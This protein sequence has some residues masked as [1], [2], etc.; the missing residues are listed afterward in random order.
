METR[1]AQ[2]EN[3][4][5]SNIEHV[6][7]D[8]DKTLPAEHLFNLGKTIVRK[9][10]PGRMLSE[11][12]LEKWKPE[13]ID[14]IWNEM[15]RMDKEQGGGL[16]RPTGEPG[17]WKN[18]IET[19]L[20]NYKVSIASFSSFKPIIE[21]YL[22]E[23][24]G[25]KKSEI[26]KIRIEA[27]LPS[28]DNQSDKMRHIHRIVNN[29][30]P[31]TPI[32]TKKPL[33]KEEKIAV[34]KQSILI[35]DQRT[36]V[37]AIW[38]L[39]K[40]VVG[41]ENHGIKVESGGVNNPTVVIGRLENLLGI[42]FPDITPTISPAKSDLPKEAVR[43]FTGNETIDFIGRAT[44]EKLLEANSSYCILR[45][46]KE[47]GMLTITFF[48]TTNEGTPPSPAE[49]NNYRFA[50][51]RIK[52]PNSLEELK[53]IL[54]GSN[55]PK[56]KGLDLESLTRLNLDSFPKQ[57]N[58]EI[59]KEKPAQPKLSKQ[60]IK[61]EPI[62]IVLKQT[63]TTPLSAWKRAKAAVSGSTANV[64]DKF[65][66]KHRDIPGWKKGFFKRTDSMEQQ[67]VVKVTKET[68]NEDK[69][70]LI[71]LKAATDYVESHRKELFPD[72]PEYICFALRSHPEK[73]SY[74][75]IL[76]NIYSSDSHTIKEEV[77]TEKV[78][79]W[80][81]L[82]KEEETKA[83]EFLQRKNDYMD[84]HSIL[85]KAFSGLTDN[86][87]ERFISSLTSQS[88]ETQRLVL[89]SQSQNDLFGIAKMV[90][91]TALQGE[92]MQLKQE[93]ERF[94]EKKL[95]SAAEKSL[96]DAAVRKN[97]LKLDDKWG[98]S[99]WVNVEE[100]KIDTQLLLETYLERRV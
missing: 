14:A 68:K 64:F 47:S 2:Q 72:V 61:E 69:I 24:I 55:D 98:S 60:E 59:E 8:F 71:D 45:E 97:Y 43:I 94:D 21:K 48:N 11:D 38:D 39:F 76:T 83:Q 26:S 44:K 99:V 86:D 7:F 36:N 95:K 52:D 1:G 35:D 16:L 53:A 22:E 40:G 57:Q 90:N 89:K 42:K 27:W 74:Q 32:D 50:N 54:K 73:N 63:K 58:K 15:K 56:L 85:Q 96:Y 88:E 3:A 100:K 78:R 29:V 46:S 81:D 19:L 92:A 66:G 28:E 12:Q 62:P 87:K 49:I 65:I 67:S 13:E 4:T 5:V 6:I 10:F 23:V 37:K 25:L 33:S 18:I 41:G 31:K 80:A 93:R 91:N 75:L 82:Q 17:E 84:Q 20:R 77:S 70:D 34:C 9:L 30:D 79:E 51:G